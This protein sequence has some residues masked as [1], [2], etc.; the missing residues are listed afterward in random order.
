MKD[1]VALF[2]VV[3][4]IIVTFVFINRF[5]FNYKGLITMVNVIDI[6]KFKV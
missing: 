4:F 5:K 2:N 3:R 1:L 6:V